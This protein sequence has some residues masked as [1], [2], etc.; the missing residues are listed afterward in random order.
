MKDELV[1]TYETL[2]NNVD[3]STEFP[4]YILAFCPDSDSWFATNQ[5]FFYYEYPMDFPNEKAAIDYFKR[6]PDVFLKIEEGMGVY[7]P[8]FFDGGVWLENTRQLVTIGGADS[9]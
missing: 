8:S 9:G 7:R 3:F 1:T 6:N 4:T 5:R 2:P